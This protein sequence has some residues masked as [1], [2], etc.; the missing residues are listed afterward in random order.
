M[1]NAVPVEGPYEVHDFTVNVASGIEKY[2]LLQLID[3]RTAQ[4]SAAGSELWA[5]I[6]ASEKVASANNTKT[7]LGLYTKGVFLLV[8]S[9]GPTIA[10]GSLVSLS[11]NNAIK[12]ATSG[13]LLTGAVIGKALQE[14]AG[15]AAGE[16]HVG[17]SA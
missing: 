11:G 4:A 5:G 2:A 12:L 13:E 10:V 9:P 15:G 6:A 7:E 3:P 8:N 17:A 14:I 1:T 16:V